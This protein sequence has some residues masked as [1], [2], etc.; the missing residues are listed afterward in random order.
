MEMFSLFLYGLKLGSFTNGYLIWKT[1]S[2]ENVDWCFLIPCQIL[3]AVNLYRCTF[4]LRYHNSIVLHDNFLTSVFAT[5]LLATFSEIA[6]I[7]ELSCVIHDLNHDNIPMINY[8]AWM[9]VGLST[10]GQCFVWSAIISGRPGLMF[11]E[12]TCWGILFLIN[13]G[14]NGYFYWLYYGMGVYS[15]SKEQLMMISI[16]FGILYLPWQFLFHIPIFYQQ[17]KIDSGKGKKDDKKR[18]VWCKGLFTRNKSVNSKDWGGIVG[19]IW[20]VGYWICIP[21]WMYLIVQTYNI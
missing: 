15:S 5:R 3:A 21:Y 9:M 17:R 2:M 12:E 13:T 7:Y 6:Y 19:I 8:L 18:G 20:M 10:S 11:F 1:F 14:L 16:I 4:P